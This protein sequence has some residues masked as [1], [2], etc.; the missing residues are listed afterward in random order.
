LFLFDVVSG[1]VKQFL[2]L[3]DAMAPVIPAKRLVFTTAVEFGASFI[4]NQGAPAVD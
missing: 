1:H 4:D 3:L 2:Q